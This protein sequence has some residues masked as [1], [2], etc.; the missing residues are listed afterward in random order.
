MGMR[1]MG[2]LIWLS[3]FQVKF[4]N[5]EIQ[6]T[7]CEILSQRSTDWH[8][9][10]LGSRN[11]TVVRALPSH[12]CDLVSIPAG[13]ICGLSLVL[14]LAL[15]QGFFSGFSSFPPS[16]KSNILKFQF[17]QNR[18]P[19]WKPAKAGVGSSLNIFFCNL[20]NILFY[21]LAWVILNCLYVKEAQKG[22]YC[23]C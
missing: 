21:F 12:Q 1:G 23:K 14:V 15:L 13:A 2:S 11:G 8:T 9:C 5:N 16:T 18:E 10:I 4:I 19:A 7:Y 17:D 20:F 22:S 6:M 3:Q